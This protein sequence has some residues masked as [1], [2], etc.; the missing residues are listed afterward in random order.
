MLAKLLYFPKLKN[1]CAAALILD[2]LFG[3]LVIIISSFD[4]A[5][6]RDHVL[7]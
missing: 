2:L 7:T 3:A 5:L 6:I 1:F 4:L